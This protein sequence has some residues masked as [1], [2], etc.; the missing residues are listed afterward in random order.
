MRRVA[1]G[2]GLVLIGVA[3]T[4]FVLFSQTE[5]A[6]TLRQGSPVYVLVVL[7]DEDA[8][9]G[10]QAEAIAV[11]VFQPGAKATWLSIP[12]HLAWPTAA[13]W[14]SLHA[15]YASEG[16][17]GLVRRLTLLVEVP[18]AYWWVV[19]FAG[20]PRI[21]DALGGVE[22]EVE[23]RLVY[24][25]RSRN[26]FIDIPPGTQTFDGI[27]TLDFVRYQD[28]EPARLAR[29][30]QLLRALLE[31][32]RAIPAAQWRSTVEIVRDAVRTNLSPWETLDLARAIGDLTPE[33]VTFAIAPTLPRAGGNGQTIPDLVR[34]RKLT[35]SWVRSSPYLTR[36]EIR[37]LIL[38]GTGQRFLSSMTGAWLTDLGFRVTGTADAD[39]SNYPSTY[40]VVRDDERA[41]AR[42][43]FDVFPPSVQARSQIQTDR[44]FDLARVG[45][46][47]EQ[48]DVILI[49]GAGFDVRP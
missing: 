20:L 37:V 15:L 40:V 30:H 25:D 48:A 38:N 26:L 46:W 13:G 10:A 7:V 9:G 3:V 35:Q 19:D 14:T 8:P 24:Q 41:K 11:A 31:V 27:T 47:P 23:D 5:V 17:A 29:Q 16:T 43:V 21:V 2:V 36:D 45:G 34:L 42:A 1:V 33:R 39:R 12:R 18:I 6:R 28:D 22:V 44:E 4:L 49:L 32:T